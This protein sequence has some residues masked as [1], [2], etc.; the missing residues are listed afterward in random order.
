MYCTVNRVISSNDSSFP[1]KSLWYSDVGITLLSN[2]RFLELNAELEPRY[3][4]ELG[5]KKR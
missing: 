3:L 5:F 4:Q 1:M 2:D